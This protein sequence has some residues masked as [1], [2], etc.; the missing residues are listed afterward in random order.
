MLKKCIKVMKD[1]L[2]EYE[3]EIYLIVFLVIG[4]V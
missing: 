1:F 2:E 3:Y 4:V